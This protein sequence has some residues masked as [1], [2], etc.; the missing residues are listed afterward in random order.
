MAKDNDT[1]IN[2]HPIIRQIVA[3]QHVGV[4]NLTVI[5][6]AIKSLKNKRTTW[7]AMPTNDRKEF[8]RQCIYCHKENL[9]LYTHVNSIT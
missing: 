9:I 6:T 7:L 2:V 1:K 8:M 3:R 5:K 4:S